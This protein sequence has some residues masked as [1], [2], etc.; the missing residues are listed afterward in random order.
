MPASATNSR[1]GLSSLPA[2][3]LR[4]LLASWRRALL[5]ENKSLNTVAVYNSAL[6]RL[7]DFLAERGMPTHLP[8]ISREH[9]ESFIVELLRTR[10]A[11]TAHNRYRALQQ[12]FRWALEEGEISS[13][14][15]ARMKPP[16]LPDKQLAIVA[17]DAL[18]R[19]LKAV[20]GP[21]FD[22]RRDAAIIR[23]FLDTGMRRGELA[24]LRI[25]DVDFSNNVAYVL[26]KGR[27]PRACPFGARTARAIDRY[28]RSRAAHKD[29]ARH[30]LWLGIKGPL[31]G[32]GV[33]QMIQERTRQA[34]IGHLTPHQFRHTFAHAWLAAGGSEGDLM[35]LAG[36]R[37][38]SMLSRYAASTADER[39]RAAH[40]RMALGD[41]L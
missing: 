5:A 25:E 11:A 40:K 22:K 37:S 14:P 38:R 4:P 19:L 7:E 15:M 28:L 29:A 34:G 6:G 24:G 9:V 8:S 31:T 1:A 16:I 17:D 3:G 27:R 30:E 20:D 36:W 35:R 10:S 2:S 13:S 12:F 18:G 39:A 33:F 41:R 26:G 32:S 21:R 23:L